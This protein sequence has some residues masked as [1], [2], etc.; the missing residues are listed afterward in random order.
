MSQR[1]GTFGRLL[2]MLALALTAGAA[3]SQEPTGPPPPAGRGD[4]GALP[5][6]ELLPEIGRI[7]AQVGFSAG[8]AWHPFAAGRGWQGTGFIDLPLAQG[9][10]G[11]L[12]YEIFVSL[13]SSTGAPFT[14]TDSVAFVA[15]LAAG[16]S[17]ADALAGPPRAPFPVRRSVRTKLRVLTVAPFALKH[18]FTGLDR[19][20]LRP[21][22]TAGVDAVVIITKQV[23]ERDESLVFTGTA[24]FDAELIAGLIG[25]APEL[26]AQGLPTGQGN[27]EFG[28]HAG[29]GFELRVTR[30][31]SLNADYR[32]TR[33]GDG[34]RLHTAA[35][36][37]GF[38]W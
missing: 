17:P 33:I 25:Q 1:A 18:T 35:G 16:A 7:G 27:L 15:N 37:L 11:R 38:H 13:G 9:F 29:A 21:Y 32:L 23:P 28:F 6:L 2:G 36:A 10:G 22:V 12:S 5:G 34:A 14:L 19:A 26:T 31:L 20:R 30:G 24:P 4:S 8:P 3:S